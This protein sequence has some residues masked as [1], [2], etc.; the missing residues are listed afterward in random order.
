MA[1]VGAA[2]GVDDLGPGAGVVTEGALTAVDV[3]D[4]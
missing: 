2:V 1:V 3:F 4:R